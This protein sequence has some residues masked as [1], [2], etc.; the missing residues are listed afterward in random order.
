MS[1]QKVFFFGTPL[2][3]ANILDSIVKNG[4]IRID[5][6][7]TQPDRCKGRGYNLEE[8]EVKRIAKKNKLP[9]YQPTNKTELQ[10]LF[11]DESPDLS[12]VVA[13]GMIFSKEIVQNY[14]LVNIHASLLPK[15]RGPS[16]IQTVLLGDDKETGVTLIRIEEKVD[17]GDII[18]MKKIK[19][20]EKENFSTLS[21]K[22]EQLSI[23]M[24]LQQLDIDLVHWKFVRQDET[25]ASYTKKIEKQNGYVD[26]TK[27]DPEIIIKK[28][29]AYHPWPGVYTI[30]NNK[31]IKIIDAKLLDKHLVIEKVQEEGRKVILYQDYILNND[32]LI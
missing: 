30:K 16:P 14:L 28:I 12:I 25:E 31:R 18:N 5:G 20:D 7:V 2:F 32:K 27:D 4:K 21:E 17:N 15:Y 9:V 24:L 6:V 13:F 1:F 11:K 29:R 10:N 19:I 8:S 26:L 23:S 3:A 22:L